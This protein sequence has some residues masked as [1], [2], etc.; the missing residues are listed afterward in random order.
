MEWEEFW[1]SREKSRL[2]ANMDPGPVVCNLSSAACL[3]PRVRCLGEEDSVEC[4]H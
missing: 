1:T 2:L 4:G 3:W